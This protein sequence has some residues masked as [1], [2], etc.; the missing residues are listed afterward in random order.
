VKIFRWQYNLFILPALL[1][2]VIFF[3]YP[4]LLTFYFSFLDYSIIRHTNKFI[5]LGNYIK[6]F[7]SNIFIQTAYNTFIWVIIS[8]LVPLFLATL[9][10]LLT[11][12]SFLGY[13]IFRSLFSLPMI[14]I[15]SSTAILWALMYSEPFGLINHIIEFLHL[16]REI[17]LA[18]PKTVLPAV[19]IANAW[20]GTPMS[21]LMILAGLESLDTEPLEA[22]EVDGASYV[23]K[24]RY[25]ILPM[26]S[27]V[28]LLVAL[29]R[30][31]DVIRSFSLIWIM[32]QGGPGTS[33][34]TLPVATFKVSFLQYDYGMGSAW[35]VINVIVTFI[36][37][38]LILRR[39]K[40]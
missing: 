33:S 12:K 9:A 27:P 34:S 28:I 17:W 19:S 4:I 18:N 32:T 10:A 23:Q 25:I 14:F 7:S 37:T 13:K 3:V 24:V 38:F 21:Y 6:I 8:T 5:G 30:L 11:Y 35:G 40:G 39:Q 26:V 15:P 20:Y 22:S 29:L 1:V 16:P 2:M 36:I 31:I